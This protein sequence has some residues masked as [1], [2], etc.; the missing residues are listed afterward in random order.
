MTC[1]K[2]VSSV[3]SSMVAIK[4]HVL[5]L[6]KLN[7]NWRQGIFSFFRRKL[8]KERF[9][10]PDFLPSKSVAEA[11]EPESDCD[12]S[13]TVG[14]RSECCEDDDVV[15]VTDEDDED[16]AAVAWSVTTDDTLELPLLGAN[17]GLAANTD[18]GSG[19]AAV[20]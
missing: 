14:G 11:K 13:S 8:K 6:S 1:G 16:A 12:S 19:S 5:F 3:F 7:P 10:L 4:W 20:A 18:L 2:V 9:F 15:V 17:G